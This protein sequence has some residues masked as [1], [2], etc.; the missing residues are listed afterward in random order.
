MSV[1]EFL[2]EVIRFTFRERLLLKLNLFMCLKPQIKKL[3]LVVLQPDKASQLLNNI[4][5]LN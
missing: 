3:A 2:K 1:I 5:T 4:I